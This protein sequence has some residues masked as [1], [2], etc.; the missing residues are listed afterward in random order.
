MADAIL[1]PEQRPWRANGRWMTLGLAIVFTILLAQAV[2]YSGLIERFAEWEFAQFGRYFPALTLAAFVGLF[3]LVWVVVAGVRR[4]LAAQP[5][6]A[7]R[8][9]RDIGRLI[10]VRRILIAVAILAGIVAL[11]AAVRLI[12]LPGMSGPVR[13]V[14]LSGRAPVTLAGG[15]VQLNGIAAIGPIA[16]QTTDLM[17]DRHTMFLVPVGRTRLQNGSEGYNLFVQSTTNRAESVPVGMRGLLRLDALPRDIRTLYRNHDIAV[18]DSSAVLFYG[19]ASANRPMVILIIEAI[20][21]GAIA[22][23]FAAYLKRRTRKLRESATRSAML[24]G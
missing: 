16:R 21:V 1:T 12:S 15:P 9:W 23:L 19:P 24:V 13:T 4:R 22:L 10:S 6:E 5:D 3:A 11:A 20:V 8:V 17:F 14:D 18:A 7:E 2:S